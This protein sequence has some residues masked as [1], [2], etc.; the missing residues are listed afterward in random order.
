M[1]TAEQFKALLKSHADGDDHR[2]YS[3]ALQVAAKEARQGHTKLASDIKSLVEKSQKEDKVTAVSAKTLPF[4]HQPKSELK[5][6]LELTPSD[7]HVEELVLSFDIKER[8]EKVVTEQ[9]Q[10]DRLREFGL[11]PRRKLLFTGPPGTGKTMSA[12]MLATELRL[13][14]YTIVLD[15][16]ITRYMGETAAKLRLVFDHIRQTRAV[17]LFDEFDAIGTQRGASNDVGEIR[18]VLNSFLLFVEQDYSESVIVAATNHPELLDQ[19][20]YRRFDDIIQFEKPQLD[21]I[22]MLME[23]RLSLFNLDEL[24][25]ELV[26]QKALGLSSAEITQSCDDA[27]KDAVLYFDGQLSSDILIKALVRRN[28]RVQKK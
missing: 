25:W 12:L 27:A 7:V 6:L 26:T 10:K 4:V 5:G 14:L 9:R 21:Q 18:R 17:Y 19:A 16:L 3:I 13:P 8:L 28:S 23:N 1:A 2:F 22:N 11:F 15:S 24:D 20:L